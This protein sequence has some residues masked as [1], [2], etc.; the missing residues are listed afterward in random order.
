MAG[1]GMTAETHKAVDMLSA[2]QSVGAERFHVTLIDI[3]GH[4][5]PKGELLSYAKGQPALRSLIGSRASETS[6]Y[7]PNRHINELRRSIGPLLEEAADRQHNVIIRPIPTRA[8]LVQLDDPPHVSIER[9]REAAF[10]I[11]RTSANGHQVWLALDEKPDLEF[12]RRLKKG[13][14]A[15]IMA[16][17]ATRIAGSL[18]FK[19]SY[20]PA[21]PCVE[22]IHASPGRVI[23]RA[24]LENLS[25]LA[26]PQPVRPAPVR[27]S[28]VS[29]GVR[30]WPSYRRCLEGAPLNQAGDGPDRSRADFTWCKT[31]LEWGI[32]SGRPYNHEEVAARLIQESEKAR[33]RGEDYALQTV[34][35]AASAVERENELA[36]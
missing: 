34:R 21:F 5:L 20:A 24:V 35:S 13:V 26:P 16:T 32:R 30:K 9:L 17:G 8:A 15:D 18:N 2:F 22:I 29:R 1:A 19:R 23:T 27:V 11:H 36:R 6:G 33:E 3:D 31:A 7:M 28:Q 10:L 12:K 14:G 25:I 4:Q